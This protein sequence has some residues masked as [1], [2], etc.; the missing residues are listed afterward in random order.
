[1]SSCR[2]GPYNGCATTRQRRSGIG[3]ASLRSVATASATCERRNPEGAAHL[4]LN[5]RDPAPPSPRGSTA[6]QSPRQAIGTGPDRLESE[7]EFKPMV[8][9]ATCDE[10]TFSPND[11]TDYLAGSRA[12]LWLDVGRP[13]HLG[14]FVGFLSHQLSE[15]GR[16]HRHGLAGKLRQAAL[17]LR[18][19]QYRVHRL[20]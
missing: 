5:F 20:I 7:R 11:V 2:Y 12:S 16:H 8:P 18:I 19:G 15:F 17:Q 1:M 9:V 10:P 3:G 14:P 13:D 6:P 4:V